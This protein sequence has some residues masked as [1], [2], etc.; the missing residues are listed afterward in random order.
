MATHYKTSLTALGL[1]FGAALIGPGA[2]AQ[3]RGELL[4]S[5][6]CVFCHTTE[7]HWRG[8]KLATD[9][10]SLCVQV[11]RWQGNAG[12]AWNEADI[13]EVATYLNESIY[14]YE[15]TPDSLELGAS[16]PSSLCTPMLH[17]S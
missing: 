16:V 1:V 14:R 15:Q 9:W 5:T 13:R 6:H 7:V 2:H 10:T 3:S 12:L 8:K 11:R 4:Y 17:R